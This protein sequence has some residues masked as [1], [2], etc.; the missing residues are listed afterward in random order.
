MSRPIK[1]DT[2]RDAAVRSCPASTGRPDGWH[3]RVDGTRADTRVLMIAVST[4]HQARG[5]GA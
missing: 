2:H 4:D 3:A 1:S 5:G